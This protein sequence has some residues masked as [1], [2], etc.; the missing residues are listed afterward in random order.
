[1]GISLIRNKMMND[2]K[3]LS[4]R[5][6]LSNNQNKALMSFLEGYLNEIQA[7]SVSLKLFKRTVDANNR[8]RLKLSEALRN[9]A[10]NKFQIKVY[11]ERFGLL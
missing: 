4:R 5:I 11:N 8:L 10:N 3:Q 6:E 7:N 1:M 9:G 2:F